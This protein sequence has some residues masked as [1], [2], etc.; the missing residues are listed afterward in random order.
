[1]KSNVPFALKKTKAVVIRVI[2]SSKRYSFVP[3]EIEVF[4]KK[5]IYAR[6]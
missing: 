5:Q 1:M 4:C 3:F 6:T 2:N